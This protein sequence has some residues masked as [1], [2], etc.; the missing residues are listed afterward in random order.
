MA[1]PLRVLPPAQIVNGECRDQQHLP[2]SSEADAALD[3]PDP[4]MC[5]A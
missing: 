4:S 5:R 1:A 3:T 2:R